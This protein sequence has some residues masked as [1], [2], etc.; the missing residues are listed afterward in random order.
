MLFHA[1]VLLAFFSFVERCLHDLLQQNKTQILQLGA[2]AEVRNPTREH[3]AHFLDKLLINLHELNQVLGGTAA[4]PA[5]QRHNLL[6]YDELAAI[7]PAGFH[8]LIFEVRVKDLP[9]L[10]D[11]DFAG[12]QLYLHARAAGAHVLVY[13]NYI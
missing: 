4:M 12:L 9:Y 11:V 5:D 8:S 6:V 10:L 7:F 1:I 3:C 2:L 13:L